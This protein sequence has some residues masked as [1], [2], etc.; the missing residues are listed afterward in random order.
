V[1]ITADEITMLGVRIEEKPG[2]GPM[3]ETDP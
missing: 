1:I 3:G 2:S